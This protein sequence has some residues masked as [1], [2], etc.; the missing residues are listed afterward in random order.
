MVCALPAPA[1]APLAVVADDVQPPS[2]SAAITAQAADTA[3]ERGFM[4]GET[5]GCG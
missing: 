4:G 5:P 3:V 1:L 2:A